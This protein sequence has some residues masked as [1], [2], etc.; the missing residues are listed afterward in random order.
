MNRQA[1]GMTGFATTAFATTVFAML[2]SAAFVLVALPSTALGG[3]AHR[4]ITAKGASNSQTFPDSIGENPAAPD[5]TSIQVSNDDAGN[6]TFKV[7][8][9]NRPALTPDMLV[10]IYLD[11]DNNPKTGDPQTFGADY[12]IQLVAGEVDLFPWT[13]SDY[14]ASVPTPSLTYSYGAAGATI[15]VSANDLGKTKTFNFAVVAVSGITVD[16]NGNP[17]GTNSVSDVAP[18]PGHGAY[19]YQVLTT[20]KLS[21]SAFTTSPKPAKAGKP[22]SAGLAVNE[23]DTDGPVKAGT[24]ACTATVAGKHLPAAHKG[25]VANGIATCVWPLPKK[26]KGLT[27]RGTITLTVRGTAVHRSFSAKIT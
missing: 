15:H 16:E 25:G 24:V 27:I 13:G 12:V 21:V 14:G 2:L 17:D 20:L 11:T 19:K 6:L 9:S 10:A 1:T 18:D 26:D 22:F 3:E 7:N 8:I 23:N 4:A 5:I